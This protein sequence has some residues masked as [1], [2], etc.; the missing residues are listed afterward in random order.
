MKFAFSLFKKIFQVLFL[1]TL[2]IANLFSNMFQKLKGRWEWGKAQTGLSDLKYLHY[3]SKSRPKKYLFAT[4]AD[5]TIIVLFALFMIQPATRLISPLINP[6]QPLTEDKAQGGHE[7][8]GFAPFWTLDKL[9]NVNWDVLT[10]LAYFSL[11]VDSDGSIIKDDPGYRTFKS[12]EVTEVFKTAHANGTRVVLTITQ[13]DNASIRSIM[14]SPEAQNRLIGEA[15]SE[16]RSRGIDGINVGFEYGSD[17]GQDY[18]NKFS[19]F[20]KNLTDRMHM[21]VPNSKVTVSVYASAVK[22]PK[23]YDLVELGKQDIQI[24]MMAYDFGYRGSE[25]AIPTAPLYG[26]KE[27][28]YW[29]DVSTA[30]DDFLVQMPAEKLILGTPW[31][32]YNY[33]I[34]G[35]PEIKAATASGYSGTS[36]AQ[37]YA[38]VKDEVNPDM[39]GITEFKEGWDDYGKVSWKAYRV[40]STDMWRMVFIEDKSSLGIKFDFAKDKKLAGVGMWALG[41]D[42][43]KGELWALLN[44]KFGTKLADASVFNK[45]IRD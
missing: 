36:R 19:Q 34:W 15:V 33:P 42:D 8:F 13:M 27:G 41:F 23:I 29:Y 25:N 18:R 43:G 22:E 26:H 4:V 31:Y 40:A 5:I 28:K 21:E 17:P 11:E 35:E 12:K 44:E 32:G 45:D 38:I 20:V 9:D 24:F 30:V 1:V 6:L 10:T 39:E 14:D 37:T 2:V 16:V 7:V 3:I